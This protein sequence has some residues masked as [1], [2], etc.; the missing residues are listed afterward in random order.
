VLAVRS[1]AEAGYLERFFREARTAAGLHHTNIVPVFD[2]GQVADTPYY[3]MQYIEGRGLNEVLKYSRADKGEETASGAAPV[4]E[5]TTEN[6]QD[7]FRWVAGIG[8][9]AAEGLSH[10]HERKVVHLDIKPSN[11]LLDKEGVVWIA[12][13]GLARSIEDPEMTRSGTV[14]GTPR[15]MSPEQAQAATRP[16]DHR[17]DIY[18]L[19]ATLYELLSLRPA[20]EG[21]TPLDVISQ[22]LTREPV[23]LQRLNREIP[24]DLATIVMKAMAK[25]PEDRYQSAQELADDLNRWLKMEPIRAKPI[26]PVGRTF[27]WCRR[28]PRLAAVTAV[29]ATIILALSGIYY[30]SLMK[31]NTDTRRAFVHASEERDRANAARSQA[32]SAE[33]QA[34]AAADV[35]QKSQ[36]LAEYERN[37][38]DLQRR[39]ALCQSYRSN[40]LAAD[41]SFSAGEL[42]AA[43]ERLALCDLSLRGWEWRYLKRTVD[44][45]V[46]THT[47]P[48]SD[49]NMSGVN[50]EIREVAFDDDNKSIVI[51]AFQNIPR[52][53]ATTGR[54]LAEVSAFRYLPDV[55]GSFTKT[56]SGT[57]V[58]AISPN[59][60]HALSSAWDLREV[61][62]K[63]VAEGSSDAA[64][65]VCRPVAS[66]DT[67]KTLTPEDWDRLI[68][69]DTTSGR[70]I[71][72]FHHPNL[73]VWTGVSKKV[74]PLNRGS[75]FNAVLDI[76]YNRSLRNPHAVGGAF[77]RDN[78]RLATW[79]WDNIIYIWDL[80]TRSLLASLRGHQNAIGAVSFSPDGTRIASSSSDGTVRLWLINNS[81]QIKEFKAPGACTLQYSPDGSRVAVGTAQSGQVLSPDGS[82]PIVVGNGSGHVLIFNVQGANTP[83]R[84][85]GNSAPI[86]SVAF[87]PDSTRL[88]TTDY[89]SVT[90]I[91]SGRDIYLWDA[92]SGQKLT[93]FVGHAAIVSSVAYSPD[94]SRI[95][96]GSRDGTVRVWNARSALSV[97][98]GH[99][100]PIVAVG[101]TA[102]GTGALSASVDRLLKVWDTTQQNAV[103]VVEFDPKRRSMNPPELSLQPGSLVTGQ[104]GFLLSKLSL[105]PGSVAISQDKYLFAAPN[106]IEGPADAMKWVLRVIDIKSGIQLFA[107]D[108]FDDERPLV[109]LTPDAAR[110]VVASG[111]SKGGALQLWEM[112]SGKLL[113]SWTING[114]RPTSTAISPDGNTIAVA[115]QGPPPSGQYPRK[116]AI[117]IFAVDSPRVLFSI[118]GLK[119][120]QFS[121]PAFFPDDTRIA[122]AGGNNVH[123]W[124]LR[125]RKEVAILKGH[126]NT[127]VA[128]AISPDGSRIVTYG[129]DGTIRIWDAA[130]Y[131]LLLTLRP[132]N[133]V[134]ALAVSSDSDTIAA[135]S[136]DGSIYLW[137][138]GPPRER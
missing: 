25:A 62:I 55:A 138:A 68:V 130:R 103:Q 22:I 118:P 105:V 82:S 49:S 45:S 50:R 5:A 111:N 98:K 85:F 51:R 114:N 84:I 131:E 19:G 35:S 123:I 6:I 29:A 28:N 102:G 76:N 134:T 16:V 71:A 115:V 17:S 10:A 21:K 112:K 95:V 24:S 59:G 127:V 88:V 33:Q 126:N 23:A 128:I 108:H 54:D 14:V 39:E 64:R 1:M 11:L 44:L 94:G 8:I 110:L 38:A 20:F 60:S 106:L 116:T 32:E 4:R 26:G 86:S 69:T 83:L 137:Y 107:S 87:S 101:L 41:M 109:G 75:N 27:R 48:V 120:I 119:N 9:Q 90:A 72:T 122:F 36:K 124:D 34:K 74:M 77:S 135:G 66:V 70:V 58:I 89:N 15:Y 18:S 46:A 129:L 61:N 57:R 40:L 117:L 47:L 81:E 43:R 121:R 67:P 93:T 37:K 133:V 12:D 31:E 91:N 63:C 96:S 136:F 97:L 99:N 65:S 104:E 13:F 132:P 30:A 73:G 92:A 7:Y 113:A 80:R 2:V 3:A 53:G 78:S 79:S 42:D 100:L 52:L 56:A 125:S